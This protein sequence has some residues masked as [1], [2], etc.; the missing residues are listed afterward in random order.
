MKIILSSDVKAMKEI[1]TI[2]S[3][4]SGIQYVRF[5]G[6]SILKDFYPF[7]K[8]SSSA[9]LEERLSHTPCLILKNGKELYLAHINKNI[10]LVTCSSIHLCANCKHLSSLPTNLGGCEKVRDV[11]PEQVIMKATNP[12]LEIKTSKRIEKYN[13]INFGVETFNTTHNAFIVFK[14][15]NFQKCFKN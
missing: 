7:E 2:K 12:L 10:K 1:I 15:N 11:L 8:V 4:L 14:C 9:L 5:K 13:F 3:D 6:N